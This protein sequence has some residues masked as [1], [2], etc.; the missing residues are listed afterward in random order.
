MKNRFIDS[1]PASLRALF[2]PE[3]Q[4]IDVRSEIEFAAGAL[5]N[6]INLPILHTHERAI[7]GTTY[8]EHGSDTAVEVGFRLVSGE[9]RKERI[10]K[11]QEACHHCHIAA[12]LCWR[13]GMRS[14][15][16]QQ[17]LK[18]TGLDV[19]RIEGGYKF[20]RHYLE[21]ELKYIFSTR[22]VIPIWGMTGC[23]KTSHLAPLGR[24][25]G[26]I[27]LEALAC[28][29]GSA[30]G[31][32]LP[33]QPA[34]PTFEN[35]ISIEAIRIPPHVPIIIEA[36]SKTIGKRALP[37]VV[38]N[39][40]MCSEMI[41]VEDSL[42][43]RTER[44][45]NEYIIFL[46]T[47]F[48]QKSNEGDS[49]NTPVIELGNFLRSCL[50][51]IAKRLGSERTHKIEGM[52]N[53]ALQCQEATGSLEKHKDWIRIL[54]SDYYDPQYMHQLNTKPKSK[55]IAKCR[56][57]ELKEVVEKHQKDQFDCA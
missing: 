6:S 16:A 26:F 43:A 1:S 53:Q 54:L 42:E 31:C 3:V 39:S 46:L 50:M 52:L 15:I 25:F 47:S 17:W 13:G 11:W 19:P 5:S 29:R 10:Q 28:H 32:V 33:T 7:V 22:R 8:A 27:D 4:L 44:I 55:L 57:E 40:I 34:Q 37:V 49:T 30:F 12:L 23:G 20:L 21:E 48:Q 38:W 36:E 18:E 41:L 51:R 9:K 35:S 56:P 45:V 14:T 2:A 24:G